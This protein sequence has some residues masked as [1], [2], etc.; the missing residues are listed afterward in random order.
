VVT[1]AYSGGLSTFQTRWGTLSDP[2]TVQSAPRCGFTVVGTAGVI[3]SW[4]YADH[5]TLHTAQRP[6]GSAVP[7]DVL[8]P[9]ERDHLG[10]LIDALERGVPVE[11]PS[12]SDISRAGQQIVDAAVASA[13]RRTTVPLAEP[14]TAPL[15]VGSTR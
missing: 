4:D 14:A 2:W 6:E 3:T 13:R 15:T 8:A 5:V 11:G 1:A 10:F 12:S 7:V 9:A